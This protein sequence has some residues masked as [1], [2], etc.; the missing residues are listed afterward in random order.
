MR[1]GAVAENLLERLMLALGV[2]PT[3][4]LDTMVALLL[5]RTVMA[6]TRLGIFEALEP[7][8]LPAEQVAAV[9]GTDVRATEKL[10]FAL[11]GAGYLRADGPCYQLA[12]MARRWLLASSSR[13]MRDAVLQR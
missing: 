3:P 9:C 8:A 7:G 12:P 11:A 10:L 2:V 4:V 1:L 13:S 5:S 6:G